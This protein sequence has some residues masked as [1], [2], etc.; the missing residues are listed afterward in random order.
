MSTV[1]VVTSRRQP[2]VA[3]SQASAEI[4]IVLELITVAYIIMSF[5]NAMTSFFCL[6]LLLHYLD[7]VLL[8]RGG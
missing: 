7:V 8:L 1:C 5:V 4:E 6:G 3:K 2:C